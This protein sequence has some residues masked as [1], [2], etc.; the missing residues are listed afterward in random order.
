MNRV[1][2]VV[3]H[4]KNHQGAR[5]I[6]SGAHEFGHNSCLALEI[7]KRLNAQCAIF[8]RRDLGSY[9]REMSELVC[10]VNRYR[11]NAVISLHF[12]S[13]DGNHSG[14]CA[15]ICSGSSAGKLAAELT[16]K[17]SR[18]MAIKDRGVVRQNKSW[19]KVK[20]GR[21]AG[22]ELYVLTQTQ[23]PA[24]I[25]E[26][27]FGDHIVDSTAMYNDILDVALA[28]AKV[29]DSYQNNSLP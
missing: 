21:P 10:Q 9:S 4:N 26:T 25:L 12:N 2:L 8:F 28:I 14:S 19:A 22:P 27:H 16:D 15:L 3:G 5:D 24:V 6:T 17:C 20:D 1:A 18:A 29:I 7:A 23:A 13:F 11:A